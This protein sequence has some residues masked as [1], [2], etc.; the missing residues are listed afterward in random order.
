M[1]FRRGH[2]VEVPSLLLMDYKKETL[3]VLVEA[4]EEGLTV[5]KIARHV[6]NACNSFFDPVPL[7]FIHRRV[8]YYLS[9][10]ADKDNPYIERVRKGRYRL[11]P[12]SKK[13]KQ[14]KQMFKKEPQEEPRKV[15]L[16]L[17]L[18]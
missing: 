3:R 1:T 16:S 11:N 7:S 9:Y 18:F 12:N 17:S 6:F 4:D 13:A 8:Y 5:K 14:I 15:D 2:F 10:Q